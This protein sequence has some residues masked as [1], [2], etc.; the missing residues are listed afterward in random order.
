[1]V[2]VNL[3]SMKIFDFI[4][5][6]ARNAFPSTVFDRSGIILQNTHI[7]TH[8]HTHRRAH[9]HIFGGSR[10]RKRKEWEKRN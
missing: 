6:E 4:L 8:T 2:Q 9:K 3:L 1:M 10:N 5:L 7:H